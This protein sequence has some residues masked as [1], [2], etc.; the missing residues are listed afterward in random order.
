M[1]INKYI[2]IFFI[3]LFSILLID[4]A[5]SEENK[6]QHMEPDRI[7][8]RDLT[9][10]LQVIVTF[11]HSSRGTQE[12]ILKENQHMKFFGIDFALRKGIL[13]A[14]RDKE[15]KV[16]LSPGSYYINISPIKG[17]WV[18]GKTFIP[19]EGKYHPKQ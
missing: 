15:E 5:I 11:G 9:K 18:S 16:F 3:I 4:C 2:S 19:F 6:N 13:Y 14:K 17:T 8:L 12:I 10:N 7:I 1:K